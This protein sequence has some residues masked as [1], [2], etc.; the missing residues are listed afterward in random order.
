MWYLNYNI[1]CIYR[2]YSICL[3]YINVHDCLINVW[4]MFDQC[5]IAGLMTPGFC[6][7]SPRYH[8]RGER[9]MVPSSR[10]S[11]MHRIC[12]HIHEF[13]NI[14][15][16]LIRKNMNKPN[17][18]WSDLHFYHVNV[19]WTNKSWLEVTVVRRNLWGRWHCVGAELQRWA[20]AAKWSFRFAIGSGGSS[21]NC[22]EG[23]RS[24]LA[25]KGKDHIHWL[26]V[27]ICCWLTIGFLIVMTPNWYYLIMFHVGH[28]SLR[29]LLMWRAPDGSWIFELFCLDDAMLFT[30]CWGLANRW[31]FGCC[32]CLASHPR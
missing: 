1:Q 28:S 9:M 14:H 7:W 16:L 3:Y 20:S 15:D 26:H 22:T 13:M 10:Q 23:G 24:Y 11:K 18:W 30:F 4:F 6:R 5:L 8:C 32:R 25:G 12:E 27:R 29:G 21:S 31:F 17:Q 2:I 19:F